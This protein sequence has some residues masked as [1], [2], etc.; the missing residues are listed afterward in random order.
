MRNCASSVDK[1]FMLT[2]ASALIT[3]FQQIGSNLSR[4]RVAK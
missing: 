1:F 2:S 4:L 3:T